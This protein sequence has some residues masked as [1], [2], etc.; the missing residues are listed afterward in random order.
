MKNNLNL[1]IDAYLQEV[2]HL[3]S[4]MRKCAEE[5]DYEGAAKFRKAWDYTRQQLWILRHIEN[6]ALEDIEM[7]KREIQR[8]QRRLDRYS[9][10]GITSEG[11]QAKLEDLLMDLSRREAADSTPFMD[12]D[13]LLICLEKIQRL[14]I[15][16][17]ELEIHPIV[18]RLSRWQ[19][20]WLVEIKSN[21]SRDMRRFLTSQNNSKLKQLGLESRGEFLWARLGNLRDTSTLSVLTWL[22]ATVFEG[23][24]FYGNKTGII[25]YIDS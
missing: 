5:M 17:L 4:E 18:Y 15:E 2:D 7:L 3:E 14:E 11:L 22:S 16:A 12:S 13:E 1:L 19:G 20:C 9:N 10:L 6:S 23:F 21:D 25:R 8:C 24:R